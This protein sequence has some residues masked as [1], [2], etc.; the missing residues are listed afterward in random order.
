MEHLKIEDFEKLVKLFKIN[1]QDYE[2]WNDCLSDFDSGLIGRVVTTWIKY[3][4]TTPKIADLVLLA[5]DYQKNDYDT[6]ETN[7]T[8]ERKR[9]IQEAK[10]A[11]EK[12]YYLVFEKNDY[13][14]PIYSWYHKDMLGY[15][16]LK[17]INLTDDNGESITVFKKLN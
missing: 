17:E 16:H 9:I 4:N 13:N 8:D 7:K 10:Q 14:V 1:A 2:L 5:K 3:R 6:K 15:Y 11:R 12:D